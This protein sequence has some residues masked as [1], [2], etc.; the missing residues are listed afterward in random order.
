M[1]LSEAA[2]PPSFDLD[3]GRHDINSEYQPGGI[4]E[5]VPGVGFRAE[6]RQ[7]KDEW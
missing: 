3:S 5:T 1:T 2:T 4:G 6:S 7:G